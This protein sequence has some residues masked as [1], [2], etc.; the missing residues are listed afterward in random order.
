MWNPLTARV[1]CQMKLEP[2]LETKS[3]GSCLA[4]DCKAV[5]S[6]TALSVLSKPQDLLCFV[7]F[8]VVAEIRIV[9]IPSTVKRVY[10][11]IS[12]SCYAALC[13]FVWFYVSK[14]IVKWS[15][16]DFIGI[17]NSK[18]PAIQKYVGYWHWQLSHV[19]IWWC[20]NKTS[21]TNFWE[22]PMTPAYNWCT[23]SQ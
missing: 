16:K 11:K 8:L 20:V 15:G 13:M 9:Q 19:E 1:S 22:E 17:L 6:Y 18:Y 7:C 3:V 4:S 2:M 14:L 10:S 5:P 21:L 12:N 23:F